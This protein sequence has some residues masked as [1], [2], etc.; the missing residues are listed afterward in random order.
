MKP[1]P[2]Q[3]RTLPK[4]TIKVA[5]K[6]AP[7]VTMKPLLRVTSKPLPLFTL[8]VL[9]NWLLALWN[10]PINPSYFRNINLSVLKNAPL[11]I[12]RLPAG[13]ILKL[14]DSIRTHQEIFL[15]CL[16]QAV[17]P[18][19][20]AAAAN[21]FSPKIDTWIEDLRIYAK[22]APGLKYAQMEAAELMVKHR[23]RNLTYKT[24]LKKNLETII[25]GQT[26]HT[27]TYSKSKNLK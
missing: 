25:T 1:P 20:T 23:A 7:R 13:L 19:D 6:P 12:W 18:R 21:F 11:F 15:R 17:D 5:V 22:T 3:N 9:N 8:A 14:R 10:L 24:A 2:E 27:S 4:I 16:Y 26:R